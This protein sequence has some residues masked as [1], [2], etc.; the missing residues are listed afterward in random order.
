MHADEYGSLSS[1]SNVV[2]E[3]MFKALLRIRFPKGVP[4]GYQFEFKSGK[5][6]P[7]EGS[8]DVL[9]DMRQLKRWRE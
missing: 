4:K 6:T 2:P 1:D 8:Y 5:E 3:E 7:A 9:I